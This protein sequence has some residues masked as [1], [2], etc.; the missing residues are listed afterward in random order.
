MRDKIFPCL[1]SALWAAG[2]FWFGIYTGYEK[3]QSHQQEQLL[4]PCRKQHNVYEC[5]L[6]AVPVEVVK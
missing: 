4:E 1:L 2:C 5:K 6:I 3:H